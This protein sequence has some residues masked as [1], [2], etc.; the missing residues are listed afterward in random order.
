MTVTEREFEQAEERMSA[1]RDRGFAQAARYDRQ[2]DRIVIDLST[3][4]Q[5]VFPPALAEGLGGA[6]PDDLAEIEISPAG[7]GLYWPRLDADLYVPAILEGVLGTRQWMAAR[8][9]PAE[10]A[11]STAKSARVPDDRREGDL[12]RKVAAR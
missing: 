1:L 6:A 2:A 8:R 5:L 7:L 9:V 3:G 12:S 11:P 10:G 4:V